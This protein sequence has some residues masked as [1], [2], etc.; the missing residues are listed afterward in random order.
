MSMNSADR[1]LGAPGARTGHR[2]ALGLLA[3]AWVLALVG[4][5]TEGEKATGPSASSGYPQWM[6]SVEHRG[7]SGWQVP[8][9]ALN[10][11]VGNGFRCD[12]LIFAYALRLPAERL[13]AW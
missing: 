2:S 12:R 9:I 11:P 6:R 4:C 10:C 8:L 13:E 3:L 5:G 1:S 7:E